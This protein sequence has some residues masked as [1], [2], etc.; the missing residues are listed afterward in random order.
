MARPELCPECHGKGWLDLR[1]TKTDE[2]QTCM[3]CRGTGTT[4]LG[5][6]CAGCRGTGHIEVRTV[7]QARCLKCN[8]TGR[9]P[10][11]EAL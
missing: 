9:W 5:R 7:E 6:E 2:A 10:V 8:G 11:P 1:C 4:A 3:H